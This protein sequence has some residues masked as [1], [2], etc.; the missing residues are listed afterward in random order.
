MSKPAGLQVSNARTQ[1][2]TAPLPAND[3]TLGRHVDK[4]LA[5]SLSEQTTGCNLKYGH[6]CCRN[7]SCATGGGHQIAQQRSLVGDTIKPKQL[8]FQQGR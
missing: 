3:D 6:S 8:L 2:L 5:L 4:S 7:N 1:Q